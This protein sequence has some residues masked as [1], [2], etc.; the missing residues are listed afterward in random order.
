MNAIEVKISQIKNLNL[1]Y[2]YNI[3]NAF[4]RNNKKYLGLRVVYDDN[5]GFISLDY[6]E[7]EFSSLVKKL[8]TLYNQEK[9]NRN[10]ILLGD[11]SKK[12]FQDDEILECATKS[13]AYSDEGI[14]LFN[15]GNELTRE[16]KPYL[17]EVLKQILEYIRNVDGV[18]IVDIKGFNKKYNVTFKIAGITREFP[19]I[20]YFSNPNVLNFKIGAIEGKSLGIS[21]SITNNIDQV[22][23]YWK[24]RLGESFGYIF[25]DVKNNSVEK[26]VTVGHA[27]LYHSTEKDCISDDEINL[28]KFY[29]ELFGIEFSG[30]V[31]KVSENN[32]ILGNKITVA[33]DEEAE[34]IAT[35]AAQLFIE[36]D[37][38]TI[39]YRVSNIVNK[40]KHLVTIPLDTEEYRISL[41][42]KRMNGKNFLICELCETNS[43]HGRKYN[44]VVFEVG[45]FDLHHPFEVQNQIELEGQFKSYYDLEKKLR[46]NLNTQKN[47]GGEN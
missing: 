16:F 19:I 9:D 40:L 35:S 12:M 30:E 28:I 20:L 36:D 45:E 7:K 46:L 2:L 34:V 44:Y 38:V 14:G 6:K 42:I 27:P 23:T 39:K 32:F 43:E 11:L 25:Y 5:Q 47:E 4:E 10:I 3:D 18:E 41:M 29:L 8:I 22:Y 37:H 33:S 1:V 31:I 24:G 15:V 26:N 13:D 17:S 21:G